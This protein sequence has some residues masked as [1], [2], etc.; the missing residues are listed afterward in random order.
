MKTSKFTFLFPRLKSKIHILTHNFSCGRW[1]IWAIILFFAAVTAN[2]QKINLQVEHRF[3]YPN[4]IISFELPQQKNNKKYNVKIFCSTDDEK[5]YYDIT[6]EVTGDALQNATAGKKTVYWNPYIKNPNFNE[7][8][9]IKVNAKVVADLPSNFVLIDGGTFTMGSPESEPE[10]DSDEKQHQ[11]RVSSFYISK[12]EVSQK[13]WQEIMGNNPSRFEGEDLPVERVSWYDCVE[14]CNK[15]SERDGLTK[16]YTID[17]SRKDANNKGDYDGLKWVVTCDFTANG[18]RLPTEAEW[19]YAARAGTSTPFSTGNNLTT[20]QANYNGN[21]PY[22]GNSKGKYRVKT[23]SV[24]SFSPNNWGLYNM[25]GNVWEWCWDWY[26]GYSI[27]GLQTNPIGAT[28]GQYRLLRGGSW[29]Y[30]ARDCRSAL[31]DNFTPTD[32]NYNVGFRLVLF[33]AVLQK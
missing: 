18:Y 24:S 21:Y 2:A 7:G 31:R 9:I 8:I 5:S 11:V 16:C 30:S 25:H 10:R 33:S 28:T 20:S 27:N 1:M 32:R 15:L 12:Y 3:Q 6:S 26:G 14:F 4:G 13:Q 23:V 22:N 29:Y 17:K 19:E